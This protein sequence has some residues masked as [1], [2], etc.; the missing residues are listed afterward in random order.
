MTRCYQGVVMRV[1]GCC[2]AALALA[3]PVLGQEAERTPIRAVVASPTQPVVIFTRVR[4][5]TTVRLPEGEEIVRTVAGDAENWDLVAQG[6]ELAIKPYAANLVSNVTVSCASG[7]VFTF[8]VVEDADALTDYVVTVEAEEE[9]PAVAAV[10]PA[11]VQV[12]YR[13]ASLA[14][15]LRERAAG[16]HARRER[17]LAEG[18]REVERLWAA[19]EARRE[20]FVRDFA[21]RVRLPYL[22]TDEAYEV[23]FL[24]RDLWT[25]GTFTY[26]RTEGQEIPA[27]YAFRGDALE[28]VHTDV[29]PGGLLVV[30]Q[31]IRHGTL[32][33]GG[34]EAWF[35]LAAEG[36][37]MPQRRRGFFRRTFATPPRMYA[38]WWAVGVGVL[39]ALAA[40]R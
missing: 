6:R 13:P 4:T 21:A 23:P 12:R 19:A 25:D 11:A 1:L 22:V 27:V 28:A 2:V 8:T 30:E 24:L 18:R 31:V 10:D 37:A 15:G 9:E 40:T 17:V 33:L 3:A 38:A 34:R 29:E 7:E 16:H 36:G 5:V 14:A 32:S 39:A 35:G 20:A 26:L